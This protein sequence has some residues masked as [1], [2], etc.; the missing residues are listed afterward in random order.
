MRDAWSVRL[1]SPQ[2]VELP[3]D[4]AVPPSL[5]HMMFIDLGIQAMSMLSQITVRHG[6]PVTLEHNCRHFL[7][8]MPEEDCKVKLEDVRGENGLGQ[9]EIF[10]ASGTFPR[11]LTFPFPI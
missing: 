5:T 3:V 2:Q 10:P 7:L 11:V 9:I 8:Q 4:L 1:Y 6:H